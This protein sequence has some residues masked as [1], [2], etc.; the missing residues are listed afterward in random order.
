M[1]HSG[2]YK[3]VGESFEG[4]LPS[5][6]PP[7]DSKKTVVPAVIDLLSITAMMAFDGVILGRFSSAAL[8]GGGMALYLLFFLFTIFLTF[9]LGAALPISR[10]LGMGDRETASRLFGRA[11]GTVFI[12]GIVFAAVSFTFR[13]FIFRTI[14]GA[15]GEIERSAIQY[16]TML[17]IFMPA[18]A[19]NFT[20]TSILRSIGDSMTSMKVNLTTNLINAG[21]AVILVYGHDGLGIPPM[22]ALGAGLAIGGA[23]AVGL[24]LLLRH[25]IGGRTQVELRLKDMVRLEFRSLRR[26]VKT[27]LPVTLEQLIWMAGQ[28]IL[29]AFIARIGEAEL[30]AH[31]IIMRLTQTFGV[32]YQGLAFGNM[33][34]VGHKI[35]AGEEESAVRISRNIRYLS[36]LAGAII[37]AGVVI[38]REDIARMF[39]YDPDVISLVVWLA[40][41][42]ALIQIPKSQTMITSSEL[43]AR[44]D[45][46]FIVITCA[47][48]VA[49]DIVGLS[50]LSLFVF[51]WGLSA[52]WAAHGIDEIVR[53]VLHL[54]RLNYR[55]VKEV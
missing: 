26:I 38:L 52:V 43:R 3:I 53:F 32:V 35:G 19:L 44:G 48:T 7:L 18:I 47:I 14:L 42:L 28:L 20:G 55:I 24:V 29:I 50:G 10:H 23:Q 6:A 5:A 30:A 22:G 8:A 15:S 31:Q 41:I 37:A 46:I 11:M 27:G 36:L 25:V 4:T 13:G 39:S 49:V 45:L 33:A 12:V 21:A 34:L 1:R 9:V 16:F 2:D 17:A 54:K 51:G 40:P